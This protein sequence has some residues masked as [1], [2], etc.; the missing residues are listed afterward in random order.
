MNRASIVG[1]I[2]TLALPACGGEPEYVT[3]APPPSWATP[4]QTPSAPAGQAEEADA[5]VAPLRYDDS[6]FVEIETQNRDPFRN[7][8]AAFRREVV[9]VGR[10]QRVVVM[11]DT[12]VDEMRLIAIVNRGGTPFAMLTD[13][14]NVGH[15]V[16]PR[17]YI[18][19]PEI[20]QVGTEQ[21]LPVQIN[22]QVH[23]IRD[24]EVVL[25][26]DDPVN[27]DAPPITR[28]IVMQ[29]ST[30]EGQPDAYGSSSIDMGSAVDEQARRVLD[31]IRDGRGYR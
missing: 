8:T 19:R 17:E 5:G 3:G 24:R 9:D 29:D 28:V 10:A 23:R 4:S 15:V 27:P 25:R 31:T 16:R 30:H 2:V 6:E 1:A 20:I 13:R 21:T 22:W 11:G 26:R 14:Q 18:G 12:P 7:F